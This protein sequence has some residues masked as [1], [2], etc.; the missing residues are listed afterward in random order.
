MKGQFMTQVINEQDRR[1][2]IVIYGDGNYASSVF[3]NKLQTYFDDNQQPYRVIFA[4]K[5]AGEQLDFCLQRNIS[6]VF[7]APDAHDVYRSMLDRF[8]FV[9]VPVAK[10]S[11]RHYGSMNYEMVAE[12]A[13][14]YLRYTTI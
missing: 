4:S 14:E 1:K 2:T 3:S 8:C 11:A 10:I 5:Q 7:L 9:A 13:L 6:L 12:Q